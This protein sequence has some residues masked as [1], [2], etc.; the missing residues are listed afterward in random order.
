[1]KYSINRKKSYY[2][3]T[4]FRG[5]RFDLTSKFIFDLSVHRLGESKLNWV[6]TWSLP[7]HRARQG[8][9]VAPKNW[10]WNKEIT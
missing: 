1:M 10:A 4:N 2:E 9:W 7:Q 5:G 6:I 3:Y 8:L